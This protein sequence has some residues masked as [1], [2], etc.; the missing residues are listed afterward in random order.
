MSLRRRVWVELT[1]ISLSSASWEPNVSV[2][3]TWAGVEATVASLS[4]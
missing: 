1:T 2:R 4:L 3:A